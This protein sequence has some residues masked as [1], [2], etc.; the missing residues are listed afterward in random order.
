MTNALVTFDPSLPAYLHNP[1]MLALN[2]KMGGGL[3]IGAPP[4]I[5]IRA[6]RFRF[7]SA[8]G[9]ETL[10]NENGTNGT[11]LDVVVLDANER[12]SK[13][14]YDRAYDESAEGEDAAP[15]C[16][17]E[18]GIAPSARSAK[19]QHSSCAACPM[20]VWGSKISKTSGKKVKACADQ[21]KL[22]VIPT[23]NIQGDAYRLNIPGASLKPWAAAVN[24]LSKR[25]VPVS[26]VVIRLG[27]N[28]EASYPQ[29]TF[30][31]I[32]FLSQQQYESL[33]DLVGSPE[34]DQLVG[35]GDAHHGGPFA[36]EQPAPSGVGFNQAQGS[37]GLPQPPA[38]LVAASPGFVTPQPVGAAPIAPPAGMPF[39]QHTAQAVAQQPAAAP[40]P[41][42][43]APPATRRRGRP[44][45]QP[46]AAAPAAAPIVVPQAAAP[47][48]AA[49]PPVA[50]VAPTSSNMDALLAKVM[51]G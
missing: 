26:A 18:D 11:T 49:P 30:S 47:Q 29:L 33:A 6:S 4:A 36:L 41:E 12:M 3:S 38:T 28:P 50:S 22:A 32:A 21:K 9:E 46:A 24:S 7:V 5:S 20:N 15:A 40:Q 48:P 31:P 14:Y 17:S 16:F 42:Q 44:P 35:R 23:A 45:A 10:V 2:A 43:A 25:N 51:G 27:F 13:M 37:A 34:L 39:P 19:P 8:D 1:N